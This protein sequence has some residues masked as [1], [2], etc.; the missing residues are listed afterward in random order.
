MFE[1]ILTPGKL[2]DEKGRLVQSGYAFCQAKTYDRADIRAGRL[3]IKEWDYYCFGD[4]DYAVA[5]TVADNSYVLSVSVSVLDFKHFG[6]ITKRKTGLMPRGKLELPCSCETGD[7]SVERGGVKMSFVNDGGKRALECEFKKYRGKDDFACRIELDKPRGDNITVATRFANP[8]Q[9]RYGTDI[10]CLTGVG[11]F[12]IGEKRH[13]FESGMGCLDWGR[14]VL[15]YRSV[16]YRSSLSAI[17]DGKPF[18]LN[19]GY[20]FGEPSA[21]ENVVFVDG[22]ANKL[23]N[24]TFDIPYTR[25][26]LDYLKPWRIADD[27]NRLGMMFYPMVDMTERKTV[28]MRTTDLHRVFGKFYGQVT[29]DDGTIVTVEDKLGF[30]ERAD[31][32]W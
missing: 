19:L 27:E 25:N 14:G 22:T 8:K 6:F 30:A 5:M 32:K 23:N 18:G 16:R 9:F 12:R 13:E 24:A 4:E 20:G 17:V 2:L 26:E 15:P 11:W 31:N 7:V 28:G 3:R 29:T 1:N 10:N 21:S